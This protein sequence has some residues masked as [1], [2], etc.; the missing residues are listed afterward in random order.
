MK[1]HAAF[2]ATAA[3]V[4]AAIPARAADPFS[5]DLLRDRLW[6]DGKAEYDVFTATE[7]REGAVRPASVVHIVVKEPFDRK[8]RVK[9]ERAASEVI[10][11]NQVIDVPAGALEYHQMHSSFW[12]R[13]TGALVKFSLSSHDFCGNAFKEGWLDG[14]D[15]RILFHTYWEGEADGERRVRMPPDGVFEDELPWKL[16]TLRRFE[17]AEYTI[18]LFPSVV[19]SKMGAP[20]FSRATI[21]V[22]PSAAGGP[23]RIEVARAGGVDRFAFDRESPHVLREWTRP[24]GSALRLKRTRRIDYWNHH[25]SEDDAIRAGQ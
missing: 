15:L 7:F 21:R 14:A 18:S 1:V 6:D 23:I 17:P 4:C 16:R 12:D 24:D 2:L 25:A 8:Q 11:L 5:S 19:G 10:K 20:V 3:L 9:S 13:E 22:L